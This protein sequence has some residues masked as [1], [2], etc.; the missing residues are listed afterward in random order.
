MLSFQSNGHHNAKVQHSLPVNVLPNSGR[1]LFGAKRHL[2]IIFP[3]WFIFCNLLC[4]TIDQGTRCEEYDC[5]LPYSKRVQRSQDHLKYET[6][7]FRGKTNPHWIRVIQETN[8][9]N[10]PPLRCPAQ[11]VSLR[12]NLWPTG[13]N[14][15]CHR[16][17]R[18]TTMLSIFR[19]HSNIQISRLAKMTYR[20]A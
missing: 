8:R 18:K 14:W 7:S 1:C 17:E 3:I 5:V 6:E 4:V 10:Q 9:K 12:K 2:L 11:P 19:V 15:F 16:T 13:W 20:Q